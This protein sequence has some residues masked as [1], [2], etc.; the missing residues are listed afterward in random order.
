VTAR[1]RLGSKRGADDTDMSARAYSTTQPAER[2]LAF[3]ENLAAAT[4]PGYSQGSIPRLFVRPQ[5]RLRETA[6]FLGLLLVCSAVFAA[7]PNI[8]VNGSFEEPVIGVGSFITP[9]SI[10][11][12]TDSSGCGIEVQNHV[13]GS[14]SVGEQFCELDSNCSATIAQTLT[15]LPG[16]P[17][18]LQFDFSARPGVRDNHLQM[19]WGGAVVADLTADGS[20]LADTQWTTHTISVTAAGPSTTLELIDLSASDGLG[21]YVDNIQVRLDIAA[22]PALSPPALLAL[23]LLLGGCGALLAARQLR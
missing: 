6:L 9:A 10:P 19:R 11:G 16:L 7:G 3:R 5:P 20:A 21:T 12:W 23:G 18:V 4:Q 22:V 1:R 14:P 15:T 2:P 13:A 17:Y 8:V